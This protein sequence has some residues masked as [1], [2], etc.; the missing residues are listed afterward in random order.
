VGT[1]TPLDIPLRLHGLPPAHTGPAERL[2]DRA[3]TP[4]AASQRRTRRAKAAAKGASGE[5]RQFEFAARAAC[6]GFWDWNLVTGAVH[7]SDSF[8]DKLGGATAHLRDDFQT[9]LQRVHADDRE[10]FLRE[11]RR[12]LEQSAALDVELR[13]DC[14]GTYRWFRLHGDSDRDPA[15]RPVRV[16]GALRG[17]E[18][19]RQRRDHLVRNEALNRRT[20][21]S[22]DIA[23]AVLNARG[24]II[25][26]N[27]A[28]RDCPAEFG[29]AGMRFSF[30]ERYAELCE[31]SGARCPEGPVVA[32]AVAEVLAGLRKDAVI[33]YETS[34]GGEVRHFQMRVEAFQ[35]DVDTGAIV[36]HED[37]TAIS[38]MHDRLHTQRDFYEVMLDTLPVALTYVN[39]D[40]EIEY[41]N[42]SY[43]RL[44]QHSRQEMRGLKVDELMS[45]ESYAEVAPRVEQVL[46]GEHVS[47]QQSRHLNDG[48]SREL[49]IDYVPRRDASGSVGGFFSVIRDITEQKRLEGELRQAQKMEAVGQ[50]TGGLAHDFNNLLSVIIGNLQLL[51]RVCRGDPRAMSHVETALRAALRGADLTGRLLAFSRQQV[52]EPRVVDVNEL[53][54]GMKELIERALGRSI[55]VRLDLAAGLWPIRVDPGQLENCVL[56][57][58]INARD[59]MPQGGGLVI[60]TR[61]ATLDQV[62]AAAPPK[63]AP[64]AYVC[65]TVADN[66]HGM[67]AEVLKRVF[68]PFFTTKEIGK[69]TGLGLSMVYGF[70]EQSGGQVQIASTPDVGTT[71]SL[72][73][74]RSL[75]EAPSIES[76][77]TGEGPLPT[78]TETVLVVEDDDDVRSTAVTSLQALGYTV[79]D[80]NSAR[81]ALDLLERKPEVDLVLTDMMLAEGER[82]LD[83]VTR[84]LRERPRVRVLV[85]SAFAENSVQHQSLVASGYPVLTKPYS[86]H[87]LA[88][89]IRATL[90]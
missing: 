77:D 81:A 46:A 38:R 44:V 45:P 28:W 69:G 79:F 10:P 51:E 89:R 53:M 58:A 1:D 8:R 16:G 40:R 43:E 61:N 5:A 23:I 88:H 27:R 84:I 68:E 75:Q 30:G 52:L 73:F 12:H 71:V 48:R 2:I 29:L 57:L 21:D 3:D 9:L 86:M 70:C 76:A 47:F 19:E 67:T 24:E 83:L 33:N 85:T 35:H 56:N 50:L 62:H 49:S 63:L 78:G 26:I 20:L 25:E 11:L 72:Y 82:G 36:T 66:G 7:F 13:L 60:G 74:P 22:I 18:S 90:N 42:T 31:R 54:T 59:A 6:D 80:A 55:T 4:V 32:G 17:I 64:G 34:V 39:R 15:G 37:I 14:G 41:L 65:V 87:A